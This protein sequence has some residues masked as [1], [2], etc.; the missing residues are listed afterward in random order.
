MKTLKTVKPPTREEEDAMDS[1]VIGPFHIDFTADGAVFRT[2]Q[3]TEH[4]ILTYTE[5]YQ[6]L[7]AL[8]QRRDDLYQL[9][10]TGKQQT[11]DT[12]AQTLNGL[13]Y[14]IDDYSVA[15]AGWERLED[16]E[17]PSQKKEE[18]E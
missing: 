18:G 6:L 1:I 7:A 9:A 3:P 2:T 14:T 4:N 8:Y 13:T 16:A 15:V 17:E 10:H 11:D 12:Q 5:C